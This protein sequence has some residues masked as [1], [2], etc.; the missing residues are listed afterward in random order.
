MPSWVVRTPQRLTGCIWWG[1]LWHF[2]PASLRSSG[3]QARRAYLPGRAGFSGTPL[4]APGSFSSPPGSV[5]E[6]APAWVSQA[7][8]AGS[9]LLIAL[10]ETLLLLS[11]QSRP[12]LLG[13]RS[14]CAS[15]LFQLRTF[16]W[17]L[18][19]LPQ[20][21]SLQPGAKRSD[22][23]GHILRAEGAGR[24]GVGPRGA[25]PTAWGLL[26]S[27]AVAALGGSFPD[28]SIPRGHPGRQELEPPGR[29]AG[30]PLEAHTP[31]M[32][33]ARQLPWTAHM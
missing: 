9:S 26:E 31:I 33:P 27:L 1:C 24:E 30:D 29:G 23:P 32:A 10:Q 21:G 14:L 4:P 19:V 16:L 18:A 13:R 28:G 5:T 3:P 17:A 8:K 6:E 12:A 20:I 11:Q 2:S 22:W 25:L 7:A 15:L